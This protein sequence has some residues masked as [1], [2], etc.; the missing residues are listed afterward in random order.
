MKNSQT[1]RYPNGF[2][3]VITLIMVVLA[4]V[5][6]IGVITNAS[7]DRTTARSAD[8][9]FQ[10]LLAAKNGLEAAKQALVTDGNGKMISQDDMFFVVR[11]APTPSP[12]PTAE[13]S[14]PHY[15][16]LGA[17]SHSNPPTVTYYPLYSGGP[18]PAAVS[19]TAPPVYSLSDTTKAA[20]N[21]PELFPDPG[22]SPSPSPVPRLLPQVTTQWIDVV[23]PNPAASPAPKLRYCFWVEDLGG[24]I[25]AG[26]AG[27]TQGKTASGNPDST[28]TR[29][30]VIMQP[31]LDAGTLKP[32]A[33]VAIWT[34]FNPSASDPAGTPQQ[35]YNQGVVSQAGA[36]ATSETVRAA[37]AH[38][39]PA[40]LYSPPSSADLTKMARHVVS[41]THDDQEQLVIPYGVSAKASPSPAASSPNAGQPKMDLNAKITAKDV[42]G[43]ANWIGSSLPDWAA[44][45][46]GGLSSDDIYRN[47]IAANV[48]G[49]AQPG[50]TASPAPINIAPIVDPPANSDP[51]QIGSNYRATGAYPVI[52]ELH[53][54]VL[55]TKADWCDSGQTDHCA[56]VTRQT[57]VE[58]WNMTDQ[59]VTGTVTFK[60]NYHHTLELG[61]NKYTLGT[62]ASDLP[63]GSSATC[64]PAAQCGP[65]TV[66]LG[67]NEYQ[68]LSFGTWTYT[69]N[70]GPAFISDGPLQM[71]A[72]VT[73]TYELYWNGVL[74]DYPHGKISHLAKSI[75]NPNAPN[76]TP[77]KRYKWTG[78]LPG[79]S[80][81]SGGILLDSLGDPRSAFYN[82]AQQAASSY[83]SAGS[84]WGRNRIWSAKPANS[85]YEAMP[86]AW[87]DGG[88]AT[89]NIG[90]PYVHDS[91]V[92]PNQTITTLPYPKPGNAPA[93][94]PQ[95]APVHLTRNGLLKSVT[96]LANVFDPGQWNITPTKSGNWFQFADISSSTAADSKY[97]GGMSL[98]IGRPEFTRFDHDGSRAS[99]LLDIFAIGSRRETQGLI[100]LNTASR[101]TLRALGA[102]LS[103]RR[104]PAIQPS[105]LQTDFGPPF[106]SSQADQFADAV[107]ATRNQTP[108]LSTSQLAQI[109]DALAKPLFGNANEWNSS[110]T[111]PQQWTNYAATEYFSRLYDLTSVRSRNFRIFVTGQYVDPRYPNAAGNPKILA[112][113]KK[114]FQV[115][116]NPHRNTTT[117]AV[118]NQTVDV[119]YEHDL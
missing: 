99:Q 64:A 91:T 73:S 102:G 62:N 77:Q 11:V 86:S 21:L 117:G 5:I 85:Y 41:G 36:F 15:Y 61:S 109:Q 106:S 25:D 30:P 74:V 66:T 46:R 53:D 51:S 23:N 3:L 6:A 29:D 39:T 110:Q 19:A 89:P 101:E 37:F 116:L 111:A 45:R 80:Y 107:I 58:L 24:Y 32:G 34:L 90:P 55:Y 113:S 97:G 104:D 118:G 33:L 2:A 43:I 17:A 96:E 9:R 112:T 79:F 98:R 59:A 69:L 20:A 81:T 50:E 7:L 78:V 67:P 1:E 100:N 35:A 44:V 40:N 49:Y 72:D 16:F 22:A 115:F 65:Q 18:P 56:T 83:D 82:T 8:D 10:A 28:H 57:F 71:D 105:S 38:P 68:V 92:G 93:P 114:V 60:D 4:A 87:P 94:E 14:A 76:V 88:P 70:N 75:Y 108:F 42:A 54:L 27:N 95:F 103:F 119:T 84:M 26:V 31:L 63:N 13:D 48:V 47:T 12:A 52:S